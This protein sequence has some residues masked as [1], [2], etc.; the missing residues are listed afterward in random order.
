MGWRER[1]PFDSVYSMLFF[2]VATLLL[3]QLFSARTRFSELRKQGKVRLHCSSI[4]ALTD[5]RMKPMPPWNPILGHLKFCRQ[6]MSQ[7]PADAHPGYVIDFIRRELPELGPDYYLDTWPFGPQM[8]VVGSTKGL[9]H[10]THNR[11]LP[12]YPALKSFL[13]PISE[14][15]DLVSMEGESWKTWRSAFNPG[16]SSAY[17]SNLVGGVVM[18]T[19]QFCERLRGLCR[20]QAMFRMKNLTDYLT[21]DVIGRIVMYVDSWTTRLYLTFQAGMR[22]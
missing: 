16:F 20:S 8:L 18:E 4:T 19:Q 10:A 11:A 21:M 17:L 9:H 13:E 6:A 7:V 12:Q 22:I 14:G 15:M 3:H 1:L 5:P 2:I